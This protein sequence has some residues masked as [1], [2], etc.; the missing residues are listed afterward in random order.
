MKY[1]KAIIALICAVLLTGCNMPVVGGDAGQGENNFISMEEEPDLSYEVPVSTPGILVNQLG[2]MTA[3]TKMAIFKGEEMPDEFYLIDA[4]S[5]E[6][7]YT[8]TLEDKGYNQELDEY[9]SYG[10]FTAFQTPGTYYIEAPVLG[11]SYTFSIGDDVYDEL[12]REVCKQY[13]YNRCGM[14]L[15]EEY[16]GTG[17][18]NACHTGKAVLK[19]DISVSIDV[20]GGWHQDEKGQ[21]DVVTAAKTLS[22]M[23]LSYE[24]Y[25]DS[26][27]DDTGIPESGNGVPDLLDEVRYEI[28]WLL[29]MQD[30]KTGA[31]YAGVAIY[32]PNNIP[33]KA[34]DIYVEPASA[35]AERAFAMALAKFS[36][37][38]QN[39][40]NQYA[41]A[42][43]KAADRAWKHSQLHE[44]EEEG[45]G[46]DLKFASAAELYRAA[47]W[48]SY[49]KYIKEYL[50]AG[51]YSQKQDD[52][53][54][55]GCVTYIS[56]KQTVDLELCEQIM[57]MLMEK[58]ELISANARTKIYLTAGNRE[59]DN[60]NELLLQMMYLTIVN[61]II[62]NHEYETLIENHLHYFLG[63]NDKAVNYL[64][65]TGDNSYETTNG[66]L[67]IMKQFEA[68]SKLIFMLSE[69]T[70]SRNR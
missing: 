24:L 13:Y 46:A 62:S 33:G 57:E 31:V 41:T 39:Y 68:D 30:Q 56:T 26:F 16:A 32:A 70:N 22:V 29:K 15:T 37:L 48:Q 42:C 40:D 10:D 20:T 36:Y 38:Y 66:S 67:G 6:K 4:E 2:Y 5:K 59:Q 50:S 47:G 14:T 18:H 9:N 19:E 65:N 54:L 3:S 58:A 52:V 44:E 35:E 12:F 61:H 27:Q 51:E 45:S 43:L 17:A 25:G 1:Q 60:N 21:K 34:A 28:E 11:R 69:I 49:H 63:R 53:V 55:M 64:Q 7:V 23:L 8:G